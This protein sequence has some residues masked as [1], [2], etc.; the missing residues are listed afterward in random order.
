MMTKSQKIILCVVSAIAGLLF[1][2]AIYYY[3]KVQARKQ[4]F[5]QEAIE[6]KK[7]DNVMEQKIDSIY[8]N[9]TSVDLK[10]ADAKGFVHTIEY[11]MYESM[12]CDS[13]LNISLTFDKNGNIIDI[14]TT[15][16]GAETYTATYD[17]N[18]NGQ[19]VSIGVRTS[20]AYPE[21]Y[22]KGYLVRKLTYDNAGHVCRIVFDDQS[23]YS[24]FDTVSKDLKFSDYQVNNGFM[25]HESK[26]IYELEK[27]ISKGKF[28]DV[29]HDSIGNWI[30]RKG[31]TTVRNTYMDEAPTFSTHKI[32]DS[33]KIT[34]YNK[35]E[36]DFT[37]FLN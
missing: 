11:E 4:V 5:E 37:S 24:G 15:F 31:S 21:G 6:Q 32:R 14:K 25:A 30:A 2:S 27:D 17:R 28:N 12:T 13:L 35:D 16:R 36:I 19:I 29:Q 3:Y 9:F 22:Y 33:R 8:K 7:E 34:Y 23:E 10:M 1:G 18:S 26:D 20:V